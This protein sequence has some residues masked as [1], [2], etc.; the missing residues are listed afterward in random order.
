MVSWS[1]EVVFRAKKIIFLANNVVVFKYAVVFR[2]KTVRF[3]AIT[4]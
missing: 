4:M 1:R 2:A 3:G